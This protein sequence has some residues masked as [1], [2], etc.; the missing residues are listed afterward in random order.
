MTA[1]CLKAWKPK[2]SIFL[3]RFLEIKFNKK[4]TYILITLLLVQ[5]IDISSS[6]KY[7]QDRVKISKSNE[8]KDKFWENED[9]TDL[10][11]IITSKPVNYNKY[12]DKFAYYLE[13][14]NFKKTNLVK[15]ARL[16][17]SKA[18]ENRYKLA[19]NFLKRKEKNI[20]WSILNLQK[21]ICCI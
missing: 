9:I 14:N 8:L 5:I 12:F 19:N 3:G 7:F 13:D 16:D 2:Q 10:K 1:I 4:A 18:A 20:K 6:F 11:K 21:H 17:R 15:M